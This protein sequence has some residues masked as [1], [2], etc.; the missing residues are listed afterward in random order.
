MTPHNRCCLIE[1]WVYI[2]TWGWCAQCTQFSTLRQ[3]G[4]CRPKACAPK[5]KIYKHTQTYKQLRDVCKHCA[6]RFT[7][8]CAAIDS[9][10]ASLPDGVGCSERVCGSRKL[11]IWKGLASETRLLRLLTFSLA[12]QLGLLLRFL[13]F[14]LALQFCLKFRVLL[15]ALAL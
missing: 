3:H 6:R 11:C 4:A 13:S 15:F 14:S 7:W 10:E 5:N 2:L 1:P 8:Q 12:L 9:A